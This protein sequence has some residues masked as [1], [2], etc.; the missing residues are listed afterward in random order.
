MEYMTNLRKIRYI[1]I[2]GLAL[3]AVAV[4]GVAIAV[5]ASAAG[6]T[7]GFNRPSSPH[8]TDATSGAVV[9][10][11]SASAACSDFMQHFATHIGKS[12]AQI[13]DAFQKSIADTL[14]D[15]VKSGQL[16]QAQADAIK[17]KL[18]KQTP[19]ALPTNHAPGPNKTA[20]GAYMQ[21]YMAAAAGA[22]GISQAQLSTDLKN[23]QSL[24]ELA[25]AKGMS[26]AQ[27]RTKLITNLKPALDQA[28]TN[29]NITAAQETTILNKL[30][31]GP[32]P[33]WNI[34]GTR[35][36]PAASPTPAATTA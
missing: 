11:S 28:V 15:E 24:S 10:A 21:Q 5:T 16:T 1:R 7:F 6:M 36:K 33:L 4:A 22:L 26:E 13:N 12:Q 31:T 23:G 30:Q 17:A 25:T 34:P 9:D 32:L 14:A 3:G 20:V 8:S 35:P 29:K 19:C 18:A 2:A 27:F